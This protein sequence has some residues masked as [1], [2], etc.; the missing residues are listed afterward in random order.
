MLVFIG[1]QFKD[2][3]VPFDLT[4]LVM[5]VDLVGAI[6]GHHGVSG[7]LR[8]RRAFAGSDGPSIVWKGA[9]VPECF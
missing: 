9:K 5:E 1:Y 7:S 6:G 8:D 4:G 3:L 2:S